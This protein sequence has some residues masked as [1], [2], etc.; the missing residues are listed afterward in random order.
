MPALVMVS[1]GTES[2][3]D[4]QDRPLVFGRSTDCDVQ[5]PEVRASRHHFRVE[6]TDRG[7]VL[8]DL[9]SSNGTAVNG[10][11]A[12][13]V[14]LTNGDLL[15]VGAVSFR[16][17]TDGAAAVQRTPR[18]PPRKMSAGPAWVGALV[19]MI[20][21]AILADFLAVDAARSRDREIRDADE[22]T[23]HVEYLLAGR[24]PDDERAEA[25]LAAHLKDHPRSSDAA[26]VRGRLEGLRRSREVRRAASKDFEV[27]KAAAPT[28]APDEY[29]WRLDQLVRLWAES[30]DGLAEIRRR[31][32]ELVPPEVP[33]QDSR[34]LFQR[35]KREADAAVA[36]GEFG[37]ALAIWNAYAME[38]P[39][40]AAAGETDLRAEVRAIDD[41]A[42]AR[43]E[44]VL[45]KALALRDQGKTEEAFRTMRAEVHALE[46]TGGGLRIQ[47]RIAS[48]LGAA[49]PRAPSAGTSA[50]A[51]EGFARKRP[52]L[53]RANEAEQFVALR[54]YRGAASSY[55]S[56]A[57]DAKDLPEVKAEMEA[58][59]LELRRV[60]DLL[61]ALRAAKGSFK[62]KPWPDSWD[63]VG[64]EDLGAA[65]ARI[66]KKP[67]ERLAL[68]TYA[69]DQCPRKFV[70]EAACAAL[71]SDLAHAEAERLWAQ[72][73][74]VP[75][76][77]GGFVAEKGE[78]VTRAEWKRRRNAE[79]IVKLRRSR[80]RSSGASTSPSSSRASTGSARS[81]PSSTRP[82]PSPS[83]SSST[84]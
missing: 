11:G 70:V 59:A 79:A 24:E 67:E 81:G 7:W 56:I 21:V 20:A 34:V 40:S 16:F 72:K 35:R 58:R 9:D 38:S 42:A 64:R 4:L 32:P 75:I 26:Q 78:V 66:A 6:P 12:S 41:G 76:P 84:R 46:G 27:L 44:E 18:Q 39:S 60:A 68:L 33:V 54:D 63:Q 37:R 74:G 53:I 2:R 1:E 57:A 48:G 10:Y 8:S 52:F 65:L 45:G 77:E 51:A 36:A 62:G 17:E 50:P 55:A 61:D 25:L 49:S 69:F 83:S 31:A 80:P 22:S 19:S 3:V 71:D 15:E 5:I 30:P 47:A 14:L 23:A 73:E 13:R 82:A 28:L 43:A 29:R